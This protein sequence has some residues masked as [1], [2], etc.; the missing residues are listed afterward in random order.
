MAR[1][2]VTLGVFYYRPDYIHLLNALYWQCDDWVPGLPRVHRFLDY[3][4]DNIDA[5]IAEVVWTSTTCCDW[6]HLN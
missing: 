5:Q 2:L 1:E 6:R 3:W 4:N